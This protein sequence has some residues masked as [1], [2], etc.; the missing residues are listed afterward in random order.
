MHKCISDAS[1]VSLFL[2][3]NLEATR[4]VYQWARYVWVLSVLAMNFNMRMFRMKPSYL[5]FVLLK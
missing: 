4:E 5:A 2:Y 3:D 1:V